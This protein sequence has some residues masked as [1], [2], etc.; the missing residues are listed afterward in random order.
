MHFQGP[1]ATK[2]IEIIEQ[3]QAEQQQVGFVRNAAGRGL[4][5]LADSMSVS[6]AVGGIALAK[7]IENDPDYQSWQNVGKFLVLA[8]TDA[9][10]NI[11][12]LG[13]KIRGEDPNTPHEAKSYLDQITDKIFINKIG[14]AIAAREINSGHS[15]YGS[16]VDEATN[17]TLTRDVVVTADR[18]VASYQGIETKAQKSGKLKAVQQY[19]VTGFA[20]SPLSKPKFGRAVA[21][22]GFIYCAKESLRSGWELHKTF[23]DK[24]KSIRLNRLTAEKPKDQPESY[25]RY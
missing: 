20:L 14:K 25:L 9:E 23:K 4:E 11:A 17:V 13:R 18:L 5:I 1:Q 22:A 6:R 19:L 2:N 8:A 10:G 21:G 15:V 16:I 3:P 7:S 24:R 12:R